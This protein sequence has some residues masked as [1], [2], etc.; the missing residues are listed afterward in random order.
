M[1]LQYEYQL[2][3]WQVI[4]DETRYLIMDLNLYH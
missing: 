4:I 3:G 2:I 1:G